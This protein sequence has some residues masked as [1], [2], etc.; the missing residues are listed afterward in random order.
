MGMPKLH[1]SGEDADGFWK[2]ERLKVP[3]FHEYLSSLASDKFEDCKIQCQSNCS[4]LAY[5]YVDNIGCLVWSKHLID[6]QQFPSFG[7][8]LYV[9]L[10]DSEL[11]K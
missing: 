1:V 4:C 8:D 11:G 7:Q 6:I 5:A 10:A 3:D 9:R 2:L